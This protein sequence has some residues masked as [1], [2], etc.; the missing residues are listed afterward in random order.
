MFSFFSR[1]TKTVSENL[2]NTAGYLFA[3]G[4]FLFTQAQAVCFWAYPGG[5]DH[6][7]V[8]GAHESKVMSDLVGSCYAVGTNITVDTPS[9]SIILDM[10]FDA[11]PYENVTSFDFGQSTFGSA[12]C[13]LKTHAYD[14]LAPCIDDF[15][16]TYQVKGFGTLVDWGV[17]SGIT[18]V[19]AGGL[20]YAY[21]SGWFATQQQSVSQ[22]VAQINQAT[23][24]TAPLLANAHV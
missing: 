7:L 9:S 5:T 14:T 15:I 2:Y 6:S 21:R 12:L 3:A 10:L 16:K 20:Y 23:N 4:N 13:T 8:C 1:P 17:A 22:D 11:C 18:V 24:E 19:V